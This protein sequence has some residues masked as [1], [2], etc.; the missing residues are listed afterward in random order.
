MTDETKQDNI[1]AIRP[2]VVLDNQKEEEFEPNPALVQFLEDLLH[3]AQQAGL[4]HMNCTFV[5][6]D[7]AVESASVGDPVDANTLL[8]AMYKNL[9]GTTLSTM[10]IYTEPA[11]D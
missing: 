3:D 4:I 7:G 6:D 10:T 5:Y 11:D 8:G 1:R 2:E 9:F